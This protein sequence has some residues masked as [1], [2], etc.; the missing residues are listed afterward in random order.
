[1]Y[2]MVAF[3]MIMWGVGLRDGNKLAILLMEE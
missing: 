1:M 3:V 2:D